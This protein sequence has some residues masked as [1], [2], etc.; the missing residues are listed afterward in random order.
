[1][2]GA[3]LQLRRDSRGHGVGVAPGFERVDQAVGRRG[4]LVG[5]ARPAEAGLVGRHS[6]EEPERPA[7]DHP[8]PLA[9]GL[10]Q[11][12]VPPGWPGRR[13]P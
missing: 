7:R 8:C 13:K 4:D 12:H 6:A 9:V 10:D 3:G 2:V 5:K 1:M 11:R